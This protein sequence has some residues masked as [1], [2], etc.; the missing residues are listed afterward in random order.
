[1]MCWKTAGW[2]ANSVDPDQMM[3]SASSDLGPQCLFKAVCHSTLGYFCI[4]LISSQKCV[5]S[6]ALGFYAISHTLRQISQNLNHLEG[7]SHKKF[8]SHRIFRPFYNKF[9]KELNINHTLLRF[10]QASYMKRMTLDYI[11]GT[12]K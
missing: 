9:Y 5:V 11:G 12:S 10:L 2:V 8:K 6:K 4:Y 3:Q 7:H 1:M